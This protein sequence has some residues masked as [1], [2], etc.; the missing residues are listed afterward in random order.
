MKSH[1][2]ALESP[3]PKRSSHD[4]GRP[5][6]FDEETVLWAAAKAFWDRGYH[7]TSIDDLCKA[8]GLMR[9]SLYGAYGDKRG[10][11][12]ASLNRYSKVRIAR[13]AKSLESEQPSREVLR[14]AL[15]YYVRMA[16]DL[17][18]VRACFITN[19]ALEMLPQDREVTE[20]I[21]TILH[22]MA[23]LW[24]T[25][26]G[27]AQ[28]A[29]ILDPMLDEKAMGDFLMCVIQGLRILGKVFEEKD[30]TQVVDLALRAIDKR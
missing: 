4:R 8:T 27:R 10:I 17:N 7:A 21:E 1:L 16:S 19:T 23:A 28:K 5:R 12:L 6:E 11:L 14:S 18:D 22:K 24:A 25:A 15:L 30:L 20:L 2:E 9:G 26:A 3:T 29:G 13:L